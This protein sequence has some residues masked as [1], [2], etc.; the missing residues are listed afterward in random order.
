MKD[1]NSKKQK[2]K[3]NRIPKK[4]TETEVKKHLEKRKKRE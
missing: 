2:N 1:E 3:K 4:V